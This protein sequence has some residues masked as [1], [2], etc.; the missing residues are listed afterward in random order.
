MDKLVTPIKVKLPGDESFTDNLHQSAPE[1][2]NLAN[3]KARK[4]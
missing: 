4:T 2:A 3:K 1:N